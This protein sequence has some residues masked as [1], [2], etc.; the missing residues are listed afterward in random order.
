MRADF[1]PT[2]C[3]PILVACT[4]CSAAVSG[5]VTDLLDRPFSGMELQVDCRPAGKTQLFTDSL[6]RFSST[7]GS[8]TRKA[9]SKRPS[10]IR[11]HTR[12]LVVPVQVG[13]FAAVYTAAGRCVWQSQ[14][15]Q[16]SV[17]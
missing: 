5:T 7:A 8:S 4:F 11:V 17:R 14:S 15:L 13:G 3:V 9:R 12:S 6:G 1:V 2:F 16:G 10:S